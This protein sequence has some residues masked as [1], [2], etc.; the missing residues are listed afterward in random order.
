MNDS[1]YERQWEDEEAAAQ[2]KGWDFSHIHGRYDEERDLPWDYRAVVQSRLRPCSRLLDVDTGGC[3]VTEQ[4]GALVWFARIIAWEFPNFSV[5][6]C[7]PQLHRAQK[8]LEQQG[9][10]EG[11]IH[12]FLLTVRKPENGG[13]SER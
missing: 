13:R 5:K 1:D 3:F 8:L 11:T 6:N 9:R 12:R 7:L 2:I 4:V 10:L